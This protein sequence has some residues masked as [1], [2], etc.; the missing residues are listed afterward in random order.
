[1]GFQ[2]DLLTGAGE[3]LHAENVGMWNTTGVFGPND[4]AITIDQLPTDQDKAIALTLYP[5]TD[6]GNTDS[7]VGLQLRIRGGRNDRVSVKNIADRAFD[8]LHDLKHT[9]W[10]GIPIIRIARQSGT[11]LPPDSNNRQEATENYYLQLVRSG[12]HRED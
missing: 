7:V 4:T 8:A 2:V 5:V 3:F 11:N 9:T 12:T 6:S 10:G 1:M